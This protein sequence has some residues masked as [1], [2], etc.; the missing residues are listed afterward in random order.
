MCWGPS[1]E[2]VLGSGRLGHSLWQELSMR[3]GPLASVEA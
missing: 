1:A 2:R 3:P